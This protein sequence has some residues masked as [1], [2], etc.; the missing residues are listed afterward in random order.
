MPE[1]KKL[2]PN[3]PLPVRANTLPGQPQPPATYETT[4][5]PSR[6]P[7]NGV[8]AFYKGR[9]YEVPSKSSGEIFETPDYLL[10]IESGKIREMKKS[11]L[12]QVVYV[13]I[14]ENRNKPIEFPDMSY[15]KK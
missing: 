10:D 13:Y 12:D 11:L 15:K 4:P 5:L 9:W 8:I 3:H 2:P 1:L 7:K 14:H 6:I